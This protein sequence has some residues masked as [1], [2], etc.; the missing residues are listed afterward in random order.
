MLQS[1]VFWID[2]KSKEQKTKLTLFKELSL[3]SHPKLF[4]APFMSYFNFKSTCHYLSEWNATS[5]NVVPLKRKEKKKEEKQN[6]Y[7]RNSYKSIP[8]GLY[9]SAR[10]EDTKLNFYFDYLY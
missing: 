1:I 10:L 9:F 3:I 8:K 6:A 7:W 2:R 5:Q 4:L